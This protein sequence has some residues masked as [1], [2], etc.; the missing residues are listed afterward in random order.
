[1]SGL[2]LLS[3]LAGWAAPLDETPDPVFAERMMGDGLAIDPVGEALFAPCPGVVI[4]VHEARHAVTL[5]ADNGAEI[6]MHIGLE[7]VA[8][9]GEGF[10]V[11]VADGQRVAAGDRLIS[12]DLDLLARRAKSLLSPILVTNLEGFTLQVLRSGCEVAVG[13]PI[14]LLTGATATAT[15]PDAAG[16]HPNASRRIRITHPHG[17]HARPAALIAAEAKRSAG[18]V[19][20]WLDQARANARSP[21]AIMALG[22]RAGDEIEIRAVGPDAATAVSAIAEAV[23]RINAAPVPIEEAAA[24]P[25][26]SPDG[27]LPAHQIGGVRAAPG[28]A[29]GPAWRHAV[30]AAP[31]VEAG[32]GLAH[33]RA[34]L[35]AAVA[36]AVAVLQARHREL[37]GA[38]RAI[39]EAH[40]ALLEDPELLATARRGLAAGASAGAAW[41]DA[42][43]AYVGALQRAGDDRLAERALDLRDLEQRVLWSLSGRAPDAPAP[44]PGAILLAEDLLPSDLVELS[45]AQLAGVCTA[46]GGPTSHVAVLAAAMDI[47]ALVA[48]GAAVMNV[49][50]GETVV[51]DADAGLL[52]IAPDANRLAA[53]RGELAARSQQRA[54]ALAQAAQPCRTADGTRIEVLAN[55]GAVADARLAAGNGA[56]GCGLLRTEF[57]FLDRETPPSEDEQ[58]AAYQAIAEALGGHPVVIRTLDVGGDKPAPYLDLPAEEN[59]ALGLRGVR[60]SLRHPDLL[61]AQLRAILRVTPHDQC[62]VMI[63]MVAS[64]AELE[65]VRRLLDDLSAE[66]GRK[67]PPL[68]VMIE[69][70]AAAATADLIAAQADFVSIGTNDLA[71]YTLAMDRGNPALAAEVDALHPAVLRLIRLAAE[72]ARQAGRPVSVCGGLAS[73]PVAAPILI[74]LGVDELSVAPA[75]VPTIKALIRTLDAAACR[76]LAARACD[77][78]SAAEVRSLSPAPKPQNRASKEASA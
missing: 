15:A 36:A 60:V 16:T 3:P 58:A 29:I 25:R 10:E 64:V 63:P 74:G 37:A 50:D 38:P 71:Q 72:G 28:L 43:R 69:T 1:M 39:V 23:G 47:P 8:L 32:A 46:R 34:A 41:R 26:S 65:A 61:R 2:T 78:A 54:Q 66:L 7:T 22:V 18:E 5:R 48:A 19:E 27:D 11:H 59:P 42:M 62:R 13:E 33:E 70:P 55:V 9:R 20:I 53:V 77:Q 45:H 12:F 6:L 75:R 57:L 44:P 24:A 49:A 76:E 4:K 73:D 52:D 68:G 21:V 56:E 40:I 35:D 31:V 17:L 14:L 51:L 67:A 30:P